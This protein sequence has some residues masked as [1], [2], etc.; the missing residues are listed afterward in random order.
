MRVV[1]VDPKLKSTMPVVTVDER[2]DPK[3]VIKVVCD[4]RD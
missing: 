2:G 4:P 1:P 3:S